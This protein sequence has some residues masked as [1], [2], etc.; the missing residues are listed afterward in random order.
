MVFLC[1]APSAEVAA[2]LARQLVEERLAAC[3][4]VVPG[5]RSFYRWEGQLQEDAEVLLVLKTEEDRADA[6]LARIPQLHPYSVPEGIGWA[7]ARGLP[8]YLE[9]VQRETRAPT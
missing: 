4:N 1:T 8:P 7:V 9:W 6:L 2:S 3:V 5:V